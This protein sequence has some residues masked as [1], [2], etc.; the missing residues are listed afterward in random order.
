MVLSHP[1]TLSSGLLSMTGFGFIY[2]FAIE[3]GTLQP[4]CVEL[5]STNFVL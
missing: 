3:A 2:C 1:Q 4:D 5:L